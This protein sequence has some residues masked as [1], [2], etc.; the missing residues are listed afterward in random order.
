MSSDAFLLSEGRQ[1]WETCKYFCGK[2]NF[3]TKLIEKM[4]T[5]STILKNSVI[6]YFTMAQHTLGVQVCENMHKKCLH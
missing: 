4:V 2:R 5:V 6:P 3:R 1:V